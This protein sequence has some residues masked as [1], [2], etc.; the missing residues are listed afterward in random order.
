[1]PL[2]DSFKVSEIGKIIESGAIISEEFDVLKNNFHKLA[3]FRH[4][5]Y[6][7]GVSLVFKG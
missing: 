6:V 3:T 4:R 2:F 1:M 5:L 7:L